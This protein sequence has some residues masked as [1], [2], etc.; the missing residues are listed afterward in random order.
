MGIGFVWAVILG[1]GILLFD[2]T[3]RYN[4][5]HG[6]IEEAKAF[7]QKVYGAPANHYVLYV[8]LEEIEQKL[9]AE[10]AQLGVIQEWAAMVCIL[11]TKC[12]RDPTLISSRSVLPRCSTALPSAWDCRCSSN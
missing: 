8:E 12:L 2:E 5:R 11:C 9:R 3:P 6:K 10:S 7:L 4:Y 1:F